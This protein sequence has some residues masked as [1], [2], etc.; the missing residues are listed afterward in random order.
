MRLPVGFLE[1]DGKKSV[2]RSVVLANFASLSIVVR[3]V[4]LAVLHD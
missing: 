2:M 3:Y 1:S 4:R